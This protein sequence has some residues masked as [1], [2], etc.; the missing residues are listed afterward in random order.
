MERVIKNVQCT[1]KQGLDSQ[2]RH[3]GI[4]LVLSGGGVRG[5]AHIG[6]YQALIESGIKPDYIAGSS[7]GAIVGALIGAGYKPDE[8]LDFFLRTPLF[9]FSY[10]TSR[11]PGVLDTDKYESLFRIFFPD[12]S[13]S[14]LQIPVHVIATDM[15]VGEWIS[16]NQGELIRPL[17]AS[18]SLPPI[19]SP[20]EIRGKLY[21]DGGIMN[22]F[23]VEVLQSYTENII[24]SH[25]NP[26][27]QKNYVDLS[28]TLK[29]MNRA[30]EL[31]LHTDAK[32]KFSHCMHVFLHPDL[33][34][35]GILDRAKLKLAYEMGLRHGRTEV[36]SFIQKIES[37]KY[38]QFLSDTHLNGF[39]YRYI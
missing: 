1:F 8:M 39:R 2:E 23:P 24:G 34:K 5:A 13:F 17:L 26:V 14:S 4:G 36:T 22:N 6:V 12:D 9:K 30:Y 7:A 27:M 11:K 28:N 20:V 31:R 21:S 16:F 15:E 33:G 25:V 18:A 3:Q 37:P 29:L 35:I 32:N 19:F 38:S 10:M